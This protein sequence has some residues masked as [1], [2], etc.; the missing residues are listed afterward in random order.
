MSETAF[1]EPIEELADPPV[2]TADDP[3][4]ELYDVHKTYTMG[5]QQVRALD[6]LSLQIGRGDFV[7]LM[8]PS[9]S[10][11]ST[12][13][14]VLGTLDRPTSG[15]YLL[16]GRDVV[17]MDDDEL[18][19]FRL[20]TLGFIFQSFNLIPQLTVRENIELPL[21]YLDRDPQEMAERATELATRVGLGDRIGHRPTELSGGQQQR[22]AI[23][24]SLANDPPLILADEPTGNLD[25]HTSDQ[26]MNLLIELNAAG[27]TIIMVTHEPDIA[28]YAKKRIH[29]RDGRVEK[30]D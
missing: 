27:K 19:D 7:A 17:E 29:M 5:G 15:T 6:G 9:G 1:A 11:K 10:G 26:I 14:N 25:S 4:V 20:R 12:M 13:L 21:Y 16:G 30:V 3:V 24:R 2:L 18:S 23:A 28:E 22:V 8:G